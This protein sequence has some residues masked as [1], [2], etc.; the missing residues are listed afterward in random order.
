MG[1]CL[2][3]FYKNNNYNS[4]YNYDLEYNSK[5]LSTYQD[6]R[7]DEKINYNKINNYYSK[8]EK[9]LNI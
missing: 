8:N 7:F 3:Y 9:L 4:D 6:S 1:S 2:G 5:M